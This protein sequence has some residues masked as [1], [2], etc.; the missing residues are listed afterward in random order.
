MKLLHIQVERTL[1]M[2]VNG[3]T[4]TKLIAGEF[5]KTIKL[6]TSN[7]SYTDQRYALLSLPLDDLLGSKESLLG[8]A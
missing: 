3:F 7:I 5:A 1:A 4:V 8:I 6:E 2:V